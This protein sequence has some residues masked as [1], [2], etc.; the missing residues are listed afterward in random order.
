MCETI[1][2]ALKTKVATGK[3]DGVVLG[4]GILQLGFPPIHT[5]RVMQRVTE[6]NVMCA[7]GNHCCQLLF[8]HRVQQEQHCANYGGD[9]YFSR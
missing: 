6:R 8:S 4:A 1:V 9:T 7:N 3:R 2:F 5:E